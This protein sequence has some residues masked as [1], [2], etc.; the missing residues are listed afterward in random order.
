MATIHYTGGVG[1][2]GVGGVATPTPGSPPLTYA[3]Y[4]KFNVLA[5]FTVS[6]QVHVREEMMW[7][8]VGMTNATQRQ[9]HLTEVDIVRGGDTDA[10]AGWVVTRIGEGAGSGEGGGN[11][12][13]GGGEGGGG[14][15]GGEGRDLGVLPPGVTRMFLFQ[16]E[17]VGGGVGEELRGG[18]DIGRVS[19]GWRGYMGE[20]CHL[21]LAC[22]VHRTHRTTSHTLPPTPPPPTPTTP[23]A[24]PLSLH[25]LSCPATALLETPFKVRVQVSNPHPFPLHR[26]VLWLMREKMGSVLPMGKS[27]IMVGRLEGRGKVE[28]EL[29]LIGIGLGLQ[30]IGGLRLLASPQPTTGQGDGPHAWGPHV[31]QADFD[32]LH[33]M[34][35]T[36]A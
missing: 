13:E 17:R 12:Q 27:R 24:A 28:V 9:V 5:P 8:E 2:V 29:T 21:P 32:G 16:L 23:P 6:C 33:Q 7:G 20:R 26:V 22:L 31:M 35:I 18:G 10:D 30:K 34:E 1:G 14:G 19:V 3:K 25:L 11:G 4:F 15:G 36:A